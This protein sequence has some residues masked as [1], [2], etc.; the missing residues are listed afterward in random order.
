VKPTHCSSFKLLWL[1]ALALLPA[2]S[3]EKRDRLWQKFDPAGYKHA[4]SEVFNPGK[5]KRAAPQEPSELE[6]SVLADE[7]EWDLRR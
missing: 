6:P 3:S 4:H 1:A 5:Y 7:S 2:C